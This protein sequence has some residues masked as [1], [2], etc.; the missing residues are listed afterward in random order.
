[1]TSTVVATDRFQI[2]VALGLRTLE[3]GRFDSFVS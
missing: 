1:M 3:S 2:T